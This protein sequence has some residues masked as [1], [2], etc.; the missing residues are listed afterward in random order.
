M[1]TRGRVRLASAV[2]L[3]G[4][5]VLAA[6][7]VA[8]STA[9]AGNR[10]PLSELLVSPGPASATNGEAVAL[11]ARLENRQKSRFVD[12]RFDLP[13]PAGAA[14]QSTSCASYELVEG[15][16]GTIFSC[17]WGHQLPAG[18]TATVVIVLE[19]P[20]TGSAMTAAGTWVIKEGSQNKGRGPDTFPTNDAHVPLFASNDPQHAARFATTACTDPSSPTLATP[21]LGPG[22]PLAT[23]VCAP[24][25][26]T[27]PITGIA[28]S[29]SERD[30]SSGDPGI[31]QVS[32]VCLPEPSSDCGPASVPFQ[33]S[34][35]ATF[36]FTID[37]AALPQ[38]CK[39][40]RTASPATETSAQR[41]RKC[42]VPRITKVFHDGVLVPAASTDPQVVSITFSKSTLTTTVVVKSS[43]NGSWTFG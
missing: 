6:L 30:R 37:N 13:I 36:V 42:T 8:V 17:H 43:S 18:D 5:T 24:T 9:P 32:D 39:S 10:D 26:P 16:S 3:A 11:T 22:N 12:V 1:L 31:T 15:E 23:S 19:T 2:V 29:I 40:A 38:V 41:G 34:P 33:F 27:A 25:L 4:M 35:F 14:F 7:T 21:A 20:S 28:A